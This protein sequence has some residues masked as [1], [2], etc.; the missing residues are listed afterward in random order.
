MNGLLIPPGRVAHYGVHCRLEEAFGL[1]E[2]ARQLDVA[3]GGDGELVTFGKRGT[4]STNSRL[5]IHLVDHFGA[6]AELLND[7]DNNLRNVDW[8]VS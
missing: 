2:Q 4:F 1:T 7:G 5:W 6:P 8:R 3:Q